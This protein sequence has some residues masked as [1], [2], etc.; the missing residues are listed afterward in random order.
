VDQ[1][2]RQLETATTREPAIR[3]Q[4]ADL[5]RGQE[6]PSLSDESDHDRHRNEYRNGGSGE[7]ES[8]DNGLSAT[9]TT[10]AAEIDDGVPL[11]VD[12]GHSLLVQG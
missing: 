2:R 9:A 1:Q 3:P 6:P 8:L 7:E 5:Y 12:Y 11:L 10:I 4:L